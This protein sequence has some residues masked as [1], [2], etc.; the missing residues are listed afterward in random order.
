MAAL[1]KAIEGLTCETVVHVCYGYGIKA[2]TD[3]KAT[4]GEEWR[5]YEAI[6]PKLQ[7]STSTSSRSS[8]TT[9]TCLWICSSSSGARR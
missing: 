2:N 8:V 9:R 5:Q 3:W 7:A 1:E 6:F 4:L